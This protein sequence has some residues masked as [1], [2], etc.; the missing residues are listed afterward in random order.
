MAHS[1][2]DV[3][4]H[5]LMDALLGAAGLPDIGVHFPSVDPSY[6]GTS[7][8]SLL[9]R[10][11]EILATEKTSVHNVDI[12]VVL[13]SPR[14]GPHVAAMKEQLSQVMDLPVHRIGIKATTNEGIGFIGRGEGI[15]AIAVALVQEPP[16]E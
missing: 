14:L 7:S 8:L 15:A 3:L 13:E 2:G 5:A 1:D 9:F 12:T 4:V 16:G 10:V 6:A 11:M